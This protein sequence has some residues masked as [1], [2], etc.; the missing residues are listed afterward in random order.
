MSTGRAPPRSPDLKHTGPECKQ[1]TNKLPLPMQYQCSARH[2]YSHQMEKTTH[3]NG[4]IGDDDLMH[5]LVL[6]VEK[7]ETWIRGMQLCLYALA[8]KLWKQRSHCPL[9]QN[10]RPHWASLQ[11]TIKAS[12]MWLLSRLQLFQYNQQSSEKFT[13]DLAALHTLSWF[14]VWV[15]HIDGGTYLS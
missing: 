12:W 8:G 11:S 10:F 15:Q 2:S 3:F 7:A 14:D 6:P 1:R 13:E 9:P 4:A 5:T